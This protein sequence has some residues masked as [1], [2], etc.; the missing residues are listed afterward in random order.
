MEEALHPI[1]Y[2]EFNWAGEQY[3]GGCY[4]SMMPP[5]LLTTFRNVLR[6][7]IGRMFFAGT[8]TATEWSGYINGAIQAG[9]RAAREVLHAQGKLP[10]DQIWQKEPPNPVIKSEPF[11]DTFT[12]K[13]MPSVPAFVATAT[14]VGIPSVAFACYTL[15]KNGLPKPLLQLSR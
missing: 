4:T 5:G 15:L 10:K 14:L 3:S 8:E 13:H 7:P 11:V 1:H 2:E 12:E 6:E 9:E